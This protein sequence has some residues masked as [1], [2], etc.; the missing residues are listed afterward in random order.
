LRI[1]FAIRRGKKRRQPSGWRVFLTKYN[2]KI[3][4]KVL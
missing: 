3:N 4:R 2:G 1:F